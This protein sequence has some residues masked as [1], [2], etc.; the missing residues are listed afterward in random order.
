[1]EQ[2]KENGGPK[3]RVGNQR[4]K[5]KKENRKEMNKGRGSNREVK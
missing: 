1:M 3:E 4:G 5:E 2:V